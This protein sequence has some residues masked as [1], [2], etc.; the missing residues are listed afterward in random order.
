[1]AEHPSYS[2][3][4]LSAPITASVG[5]DGAHHDVSRPSYDLIHTLRAIRREADDAMTAVEEYDPDFSVKLSAC[6]DQAQAT[7]LLDEWLSRRVSMLT[8]AQARLRQA[9]EHN[10]ARQGAAET[11]ES[12][13]DSQASSPER[14]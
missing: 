6:V 9:W 12:G 4:R 11:Q 13:H 3:G 2:K 7:L 8:A 14:R 10:L 1:M 5:V